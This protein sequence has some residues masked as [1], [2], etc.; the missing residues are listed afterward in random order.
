MDQPHYEVSPITY[1]HS[2]TDSVMTV[3]V[4]SDV[5][6]YGYKWYKYYT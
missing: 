4:Y 1:H 3:N 2:V 6:V 5:Q